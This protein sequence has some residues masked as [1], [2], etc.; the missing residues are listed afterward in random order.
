M[1]TGIREQAVSSTT[2][3]GS[4][5]TKKGALTLQCDELWSFVG[6]KDNKQWV[7]LAMDVNNKRIVAM[8]VGSRD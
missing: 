3:T 6:N 1:A 8:H 7:W 2:S 5:G 4:S